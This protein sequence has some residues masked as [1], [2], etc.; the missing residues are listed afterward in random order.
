MLSAWKSQ[1]KEK[2]VDSTRLQEHSMYLKGPLQLCGASE[3]YFDEL[4]A[5]WYHKRAIQELEGR[6]SLI[7]NKQDSEAS[8]EDWRSSSSISSLEGLSYLNTSGPP[9]KLEPAQCETTRTDKT[10]MSDVE[11]VD[12]CSVSVKRW[13]LEEVDLTSCSGFHR[14]LEPLPS[15]DEDTVLSPGDEPFI[16]VSKVICSENHAVYFG[17][18]KNTIIVKVDFQCAPWDF[19]I[20]NQLRER[21]TFDSHWRCD[22]QT[23]CFLGSPLQRDDG[24]L[25]V[26]ELLEL[27]EQM[28]ACHLVRGNLH[29]DSLVLRHW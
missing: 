16:I 5:L 23:S 7:L 6:L 22:D 28:H 17:K 15:V 10:P 4:R 1:L 13:L 21:L 9:S 12:P 24:A 27:V 11:M 25:L 3:L 8:L 19:Y 2:S 14:K 18:S 29:P 20:A 26:I